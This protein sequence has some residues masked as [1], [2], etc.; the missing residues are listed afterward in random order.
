MMRITPT[1]P[2]T[3]REGLNGSESIHEK[4]TTS[5]ENPIVPSPQ[6]ISLV[7]IPT[8]YEI[9]RTPGETGVPNPLFDLITIYNDEESSEVS[10]V[11]SIPITEEKEPR[12]TYA[13]SPNVSFPNPPQG[14]HE[15]E[16]ILDTNFID[17]LGT[18]EDNS[19]D[20]LGSSGKK[21]ELQQPEI[22][23]WTVDPQVSIEPV[24][25]SSILD[26][27]SPF[28]EHQTEVEP[29]EHMEEVQEPTLEKIHTT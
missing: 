19:R 25:E 21:E 27:T 3:I 20:E 23:T 12:G 4:E 2:I 7:T 26:D 6:A 17:L 9:P 11:T 8:Q 1:D 10:L 22:D 16:S 29:L 15:A 5:L 13:P 18:L 24:T 28:D 14:G